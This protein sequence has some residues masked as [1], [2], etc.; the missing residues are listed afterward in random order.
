MPNHVIQNDQMRHMTVCAFNPQSE[1][2]LTRAAQGGWEQQ[3]ATRATSQHHS[4]HPTAKVH[5]VI[6][7]FGKSNEFPKNSVWE[8]HDHPRMR[9]NTSC[10][11]EVQCLQST[12]RGG[13]SHPNGASLLPLSAVS[14]GLGR[15]KAL[16]RVG[17]YD[18]AESCNTKRPNAPHDCV[19]LQ[20][21]I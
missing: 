20:P 11:C 18:F 6:T 13:L 15:Q 7:L 3:R 10:S 4:H 8:T 16:T 9:V 1:H 17:T 12:L 2:S 21:P 19:C 5:K 14:N